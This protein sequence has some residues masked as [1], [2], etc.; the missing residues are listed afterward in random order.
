MIDRLT[1]KSENIHEQSKPDR[2][3]LL[4]LAIFSLVPSFNLISYWL[5]SY[6]YGLSLQQNTAQHSATTIYYI[7]SYYYYYELVTQLLFLM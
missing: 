6:S 2:R 5:A 7:F 4:F 3:H 1:W